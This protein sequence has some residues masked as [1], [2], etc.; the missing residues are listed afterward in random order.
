[1][2]YKTDSTVISNCKLKLNGNWFLVWILTV[3]F[4]LRQL[5]R[6]IAVGLGGQWPH[7]CESGYC[8]GTEGPYKTLSLAFQIKMVLSTWEYTCQ[9]FILFKR[10][11][12]VKWMQAK[13]SKLVQDISKI[14]IQIVITLWSSSF[15]NGSTCMYV[16]VCVLIHSYI[17]RPLFRGYMH[18]KNVTIPT[19]LDLIQ[20]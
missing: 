20:S 5:C 13:S 8:C 4:N 15:R 14:Y 3:H 19:T 16:W 6:G 10:A 12:S 7:T 17:C 11:D 9:T 2:E 1:M 18:P